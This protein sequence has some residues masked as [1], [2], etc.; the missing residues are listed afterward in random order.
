MS[1]NMTVNMSVIVLV[2]VTAGMRVSEGVNM[3]VSVIE[4]ELRRM[5]P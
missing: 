3:S 4:F 1:I 5:W 2:H